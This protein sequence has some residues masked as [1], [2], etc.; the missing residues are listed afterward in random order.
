MAEYEI[1]LHEWG[2]VLN[3]KN[4]VVSKSSSDYRLLAGNLLQNA[5]YRQSR[6]SYLS[7]KH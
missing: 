2:H 5:K 6:I 1:G 4:L 7:I 3:D